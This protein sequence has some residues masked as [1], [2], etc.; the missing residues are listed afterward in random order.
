MC[1]DLVLPRM[2]TKP[3]ICDSLAR[4]RVK[5]KE[6]QPCLVATQRGTLVP[7]IES[8]LETDRNE[9]SSRTVDVCIEVENAAFDKV[10]QCATF[11]TSFFSRMWCANRTTQNVFSVVSDPC[12]RHFYIQTKW[13]N[14]LR[15]L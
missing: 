12:P 7:Q 14:L 10:R 11:K 1:F 8:K 2:L 9:V 3:S 15:L 5:R 4:A 13:I 6:Y